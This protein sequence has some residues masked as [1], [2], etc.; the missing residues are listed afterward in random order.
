M[1]NKNNLNEAIV[2]AVQRDWYSGTGEERDYSVTQ[3]LNPVRIV[4][5][6]K[7]HKSEIQEDVS[8][9]LWLLMGSAMHAILERANENDVEFQILSRTRNFFNYI[10]ENPNMNDEEIMKS[11][12][13]MVFGGG[14]TKHIIDLIREMTNDRYLVEKRFSYITKSGKSI[15]GGIDLYDKKYKSL[16]DWKLTSV[17]TWIYRNRKGGRKDDWTKQL[18]MYRFLMEK[19]GYPVDELQINLIFRDHQ[20]SSAKYD[21]NYPSEVETVDIPIYGLDVVDAMIEEKTSELEYYKDKPESE[22]PICTAEER[23]QGQDTWAVM[24]KGNKN[25]TKVVFSWST[26]DDFV[27]AEAEKAA[28]KSKDYD[29]TYKKTLAL[30]TITKRQ[31]EPKRCLD[32]CPVKDF[33]TFGKSLKK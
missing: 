31:A 30:Y 18:N 17:Y 19:N 22:L 6:M 24:K 7:R 27:K 4:H 13:E 3:L 28:M 26:A 33:C 23:W 8:D 20:K 12:S 21:R 11:F 29:A 9:K 1:T 10:H 5:L 14:K 2:R 16:Q 15:T 32:Y 25:A